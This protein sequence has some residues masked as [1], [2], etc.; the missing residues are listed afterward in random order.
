MR[1]QGGGGAGAGLWWTLALLAAAPAPAGGPRVVPV[2]PAPVALVGT[3]KARVFFPSPGS[4]DDRRERFLV[5]E[6]DEPVRVV[7]ATGALIDEPDELQVA[8]DRP[9]RLQRLVGDRVQ[10]SGTVFV[11]HAGR[12]HTRVVLRAESASAVDEDR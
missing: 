8:S 2:Q 11:G 10:V 6:L 7:S 5:L 4:G 3:L 1:V 12:H 9:E